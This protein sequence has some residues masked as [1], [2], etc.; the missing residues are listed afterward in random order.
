MGRIGMKNVPESVNERFHLEEKEFL[1]MTING[2][3]GS[4][5]NGQD[6]WKK[7]IDIL[8]YIEIE[9]GRTS[10]IKS[11]LNW[12]VEDYQSDN[13]FQNGGI[14]YR[15]KG[16]LPKLLDGEPW[17]NNEYRM[18]SIYVTEIISDNEKNDFLENL[19]T[20][21]RKEV[22]VNSKVLGKLILNKDLE[23]YE[24]E[25]DIEWCGGMVGIS[26]IEDDEINE[27]L[28]IAEEFYN[29]RQE[30]DR[31]IRE[32]ASKELTELANEWLSDKYYSDDE[33]EN[34][35]F[36]EITEK[37]FAERLIINDI[38]FDSDG[39]FTVYY[40]DDDM[41]AGHSVLVDGNINTGF[42]SAYIAG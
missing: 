22:S 41:F 30:W 8:G 13:N 4:H 21:Y 38:S 34:E 6:Y 39:N 15:I 3:S 17:I 14:I 36:P 37:E 33:E 16:R 40:A 23:Q 31:K 24:T 28:P 42:E 7:S 2:A 25:S 26:I 9:S 1:V 18:S 20:E 5:C 11:S 35:N 27:C 12:S 10:S 32:Y 29:N 19:L